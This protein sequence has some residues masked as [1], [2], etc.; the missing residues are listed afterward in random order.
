MGTR[1]TELRKHLQP[2]TTALQACEE[3]MARVIGVYRTHRT[4]ADDNPGNTHLAEF[5]ADLGQAI[6]GEAIPK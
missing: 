5:V 3:R 2:R 4:V 1:I 6:Y